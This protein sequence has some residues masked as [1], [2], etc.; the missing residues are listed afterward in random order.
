M[1]RSAQVE[2][3]LQTLDAAVEE[4]DLT[5]ALRLILNNAT[6]FEDTAPLKERVA[7]VLAARGR[8][9]DAAAIYERLARHYA[10]AGHP[11]RCLATIKQMSTIQPDITRLFDHFSALYSARSPYLDATLREQ[12]VEIAV[13]DLDTNTREPQVGEAELLELA[14]ELAMQKKDLVAQ[15]GKLPPMPLLS[16]LAPDGLRRAVEL[17][18][19][20]IMPQSLPILERGRP[21][22][23]LV[24]AVSGD[25]ILGQRG[26]DWRVPA[27]ALLGMNSFGSLDDARSHYNV[28]CAPGSEVLKLSMDAVETL[29]HEIGNFADCLSLVRRRGQ[30]EH[31]ARTHTLFDDLD[32]AGRAEVMGAF[33]G[34]TLR[35]RE[36][37]IAQGDPSPGLFLILDG[38]LD[39]LRNDGERPLTLATLR[40]G[41][42]FGEIGLV[43][44]GPTTADVMTM[45]QTTML[46]LSR[47]RFEEVAARHPSVAKYTVN[48][49]R[50]RIE[51]LQHT[52]R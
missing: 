10:N 31:M 28:H 29:S 11:A 42:L 3:F 19:Y 13:E 25:L 9:K 18:D 38:R 45:T 49:A 20:E 22:D 47:E 4:G 30:I 2:S 24:W 51:E 8:K 23:E 7:L 46:F 52:L 15:P 12:P 40:P 17:I 33:F 37:V 48:L 5:R 21:A 44:E 16:L 34:L 1:T 39:I 35:A 26:K 43:S 36:R 32:D 41:E 27:G 50:Q 14:L 6:R